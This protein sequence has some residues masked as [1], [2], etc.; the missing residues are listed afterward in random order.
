MSHIQSGRWSEL[1]RRATGQKGVEIVTSELAPEISPT[2]EVETDSAQWQY[3]K[4]VRICAATE[5][6]GA[7]TS[8]IYR[9]RNPSNSGI[10]GQ[11]SHVS[12]A[13][14]TVGAVF[15]VYIGSAGDTGLS[16]NIGFM[17]DTRWLDPTVTSDKTALQFSTSSAAGAPAGRKIFTNQV[18]GNVMFQVD[19]PVVLSPGFSM[20]IS[21]GNDDSRVN[22][23]WS[24]RAVADIEL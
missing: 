3:L 24:E 11:V 4:G 19:L 8:V 16:A 18:N 13:S 1:L 17:R 5:A 9:L 12:W 21:S 10:L 14:V 2:W 7:G 22:I 20:D 6:L 15:V 23:L